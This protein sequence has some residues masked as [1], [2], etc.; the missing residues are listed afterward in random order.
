[1]GGTAEGFSIPAQRDATTKT[2]HRVGA[3]VV[4]E[5]VDSGR[6]GTSMHRPG[7]QRML[8]HIEE[9]PVDYVIVHKLDRLAR[10]RVDDSDINTRIRQS[11]ATLV[12]CSESI[13]PTPGGQLV[14]GI[15]ASIAEFYS[16]NLALE[17]NKGI[18]QK[19]RNGGTPSRA[20]IGYRNVRALT[21]DGREY[22]TVE[23]DEAKAAM[24][25]WAFHTYAAGDTSLSQVTAS[26][27]LLGL[28][29]GTI[30]G[31][32][33]P[34][35][36]VSMVQRMLRNP[37]YKGII[38]WRG[39]EYPGSHTPLVDPTI[40][41]GVQDCLTANRIGKGAR[42]RHPHHLSGILKCGHCGASM[43]A[44]HSRSRSGKIYPYFICNG[45]NNKTTD[46][47]MRATSITVV[48]ELVDELYAEI[49]LT[50]MET[51]RVR[52]RLCGGNDPSNADKIRQDQVDQRAEIERQQ[53]LILDAY[54]QGAIPL[55]MLQREQERLQ[56]ELR[57]K[58]RRCER[59]LPGD[60]RSHTHDLARIGVRENAHV[61]YLSSGP[62]Q[63]HAMHRA[64]FG[65]IRLFRG[66]GGNASVVPTVATASP[67]GFRVAL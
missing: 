41:Q 10:N 44:S 5:F 20:P 14:H 51:E 11:G 59:A 17:V 22:R 9:K 25:R 24:I 66:L 32:Q 7:L 15:M 40:W 19:L 64:L 4:K 1:M 54:Y 38:A 46:C 18:T 26:L 42:Q 23:V 39:V 34:G 13:D 50:T 2:A 61:N 58:E 30:S 3:F 21:D 60:E 12:S 63:K 56:H 57:E 31:K 45:R 48:E 67:E 43:V 33:G 55:E 6:S 47:T 37:Y 65:N 16:Q 35:M 62:E 8:E 29:S 27:N 36:T 52:A 53:R 28:K 49:T